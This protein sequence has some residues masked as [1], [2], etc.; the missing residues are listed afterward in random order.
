MVAFIS[1]KRDQFC[2]FTS[3]HTFVSYS[4]KTTAAAIEIKQLSDK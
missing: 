1:R 2:Q 4:S 3:L